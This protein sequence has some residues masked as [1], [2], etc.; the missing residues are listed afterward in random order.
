MNELLERID[1]LLEI[2]M[3]TDYE[4]T[5]LKKIVDILNEHTN[6]LITDETAGVFITHIAAAM[7][8]QRDKEQ[9][10]QLEQSVVDEIRGCEEYVYAEDLTNKIV[11]AIQTSL[12]ENEI[13]FMYLHLCNILKSD[14][15]RGE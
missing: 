13:H 12:P 9:L 15:R 3:V 6:V 4:Y 14:K 10:N 11:T 1:M 2:N 5:D 8:R 7:K